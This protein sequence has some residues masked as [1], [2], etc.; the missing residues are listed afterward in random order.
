MDIRLRTALC[1][2][3]LAFAT[4]GPPAPA[5]A[6]DSPWSRLAICDAAFAQHRDRT[7]PLAPGENANDGACAA[8]RN[9]CL[10]AAGNDPIRRSDCLVE[11]NLCVL[12]G[13]G[14]NNRLQSSYGFGVI[15]ECYV[16]SY[17]EPGAL[18][19]TYCD[20]ARAIRD[21]AIFEYQACQ[22][23]SDADARFACSDAALTK[24]WIS[25]GVMN[26]E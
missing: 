14:A 17:V 18:S 21:A 26:C 24:A 13:Q 15:A 4:I 3:L 9:A 2:A 5:V 22:S 23:L 7:A 11:H 19:A 25:S 10:A 12:S 1:T 6:S 8:R 16:H 20:N